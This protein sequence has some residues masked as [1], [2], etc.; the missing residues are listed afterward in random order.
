MAQIPRDATFDCSLAV[1]N[2]GYRFISRRCKRNQSDIFRTRL[3]MRPAVCVT[4]E[5][6]ARMFYQPDR[7]TRK[8]AMP[9][10]TLLSLQDRGSIQTLDGS[11]HRHRKQMF[12]SL[13]T[14]QSITRLGAIFERMWRSALPGWQEAGDVVLHYAMEELLCRAVCEW[15]G[16]RLSDADARERTRE[17]SAMIDG[18]GTIGPRNWRGLALRHRTERWTETLIENVRHAPLARDQRTPIETIALHRDENG[19]V[20]ST[21]VARVELLNILRPTVAVARF[22]TFAALALHNHPQYREKLRDGGEAWRQLF[23]MEVRRFYPFFPL[24]GGN[25]TE[26]FEWN[27]YHIERGTWVLLDM[28]GT[29]HDPR[30][31]NDPYD[32]RPERF[33]NWQGNAYAPIPQG[34]GDHATGHRC[35]GEWIT[36]ELVRRALHMLVSGMQYSVP[37]QDLS[38]DMSRMPAIP[39]SRL[40][41]N[42]VRSGQ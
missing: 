16:I 20:L 32:F 5:D 37:Q 4:G 40:V 19:Q 35:P 9:P 28:H 14:P 6:A 10:T 22:I 15:T 26:D 3:A 13:M 41:I 42:D 25:A 29:N 38:I 8:A 2:D 21:R 11:A 7:F 31:W 27:G 30:I 34:A 23:T 39:A 24:I 17:F 18:A 33:E 1:L 36:E 12:M